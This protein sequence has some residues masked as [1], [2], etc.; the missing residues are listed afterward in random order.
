LLDRR[1]VDRRVAERFGLG[2]APDSFEALKS[3]FTSRDVGEQELIEAGL[4][5]TRDD[6]RSWDRFR[7]RLTFPIR[8]RE[9]RTVGFGARALGDEKPKYLNTAQTAIFDKRSLL[10]GLDKA[11]DDIRRQRAVIIVEGY[12]DAIAAHQ[13]GFDNVVASMGTAV[14]PAQVSSIRRYVDRVYLAL[15]A[16]AAGQMATLRGIDALRDSFADEERVEVKPQNPVRWERTIGAEIRIVEIPHGKDPDELIRHDVD[17]WRAALEG[18]TPLVAYYLT[19][20]LAD[21]EPTPMARAKALTEI[22]V[23][24]LR[25]IGD[26]AVLAQYVGMTSRLLGF[27]D[28][29]VHSAVLRGVSRRPEGRLAPPRLD[30]RPTIADP[31]RY[32]VSLALRSPWVAYPRLAEVDL[33]DVLDARN[34]ELLALVAVA[35]GDADTVRANLSPE[36]AEYATELLASFTRP[37]ETPGI[38]NRDIG[39]AIRRLA[40]VRHQF[41]LKQ[42]QTD[43]EQARRAGDQA[44]LAE[45]LRRMALL[46]QRKPQFDP[47]ESPYFKDTRSAVS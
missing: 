40:Q 23:P 36:L 9:G 34:R 33:D 18:A 7:N 32:L 44:E 19:H 1:G 8:D 26:A 30:E 37:G 17:A 21:V 2:F 39:T 20:A 27:K 41:R 12:M 24:I 25:E 47:N 29:D 35:E 46:A 45:Q 38:T 42:V 43:I 3:Y 5:S 6:G 14:T 28:T 16:D 22:A 15:D 31:E 13:F 10:Y 11:Y 4:L